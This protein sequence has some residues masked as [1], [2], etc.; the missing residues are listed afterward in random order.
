M[1]RKQTDV[2]GRVVDL[3]AYF[4]SYLKRENVRR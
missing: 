2:A 4:G 1:G 3:V